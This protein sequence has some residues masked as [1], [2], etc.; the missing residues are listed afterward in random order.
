MLAQVASNS[1]SAA[2]LRRFL[3]YVIA[4]L[5]AAAVMA[6]YNFA[7]AQEADPGC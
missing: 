5:F 6:G 7:F 1:R 4:G 2:M 3:P